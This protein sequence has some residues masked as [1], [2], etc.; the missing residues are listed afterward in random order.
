MKAISL[1][2]IRGTVADL[3]IRANLFL[4]KDVLA[5]LKDAYSKETN[6]RAR[7]IL[8]AILKNAS[9]AKKE[10]LAICQD[11]GLPCV[12]V[13]IGNNV[14]IALANS[15][16]FSHSSELSRTCGVFLMSFP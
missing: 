13:E 4:R 9:V 7:R 10:K 6:K 11:T 8:Q 15:C 1:E 5:R 16:D 14:K 2:K 12:F 3:C